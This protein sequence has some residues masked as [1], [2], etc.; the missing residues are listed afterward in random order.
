M[1]LNFNRTPRFE[2]P[3]RMDAILRELDRR[4][5]GILIA[6]VEDLE[7]YFFGW[8]RYLRSLTPAPSALS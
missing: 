5:F 8:S 6:G 7:P 3:E 2:R 4:Q 1:E